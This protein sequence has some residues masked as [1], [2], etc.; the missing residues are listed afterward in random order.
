M[1]IG[2]RA[3]KTSD[4]GG[5]EA[6]GDWVIGRR[7]PQGKVG[8]EGVIWRRGRRWGKAGARPGGVIGQ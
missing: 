2:D 7:G 1:A 5:D 8:G 6:T 3:V 4:K